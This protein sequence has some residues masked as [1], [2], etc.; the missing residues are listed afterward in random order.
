MGAIAFEDGVIFG[1]GL[2]DTSIFGWMS[3]KWLHFFLL[4][5]FVMGVLCI[6]GYNYAVSR[7]VSAV[8]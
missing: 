2:E 4:F 6:A 5:G 1:G 7:F 8:N 3:Q